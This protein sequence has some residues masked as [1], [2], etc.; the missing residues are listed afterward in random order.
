M[1]NNFYTY[2]HIKKTDGGYKWKKLNKKGG[3]FA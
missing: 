1:P 3:H 2:S